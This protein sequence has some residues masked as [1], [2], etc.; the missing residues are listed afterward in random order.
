MRAKFIY[1]AFE[2]KDKEYKRL[3]L[4]FPGLMKMLDELE[5]Y[6]FNPKL[7]NFDI[8]INRKEYKTPENFKSPT[9]RERGDNWNDVDVISNF[10]I[11]MLGTIY[12]EKEIATVM[13]EISNNDINNWNWEKTRN[14][15]FSNIERLDVQINEI[16]VKLN[17]I[18]NV[19]LWTI[20]RNAWK[21]ATRNKWNKQNY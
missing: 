19:N 11:E 15:N 9:M 7:E 21:A 6:K 14:F 20:A 13:L 16:A 17:E 1:E 5:E 3:N 2:E 8:I 12:L 10:C 4:L 18:Y